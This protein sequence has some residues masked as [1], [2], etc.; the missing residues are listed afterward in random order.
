MS[1][2]P[3]D[4]RTVLWS[5]ASDDPAR[6]EGTQRVTLADDQLLK[7]LAGE[8]RARQS[9]ADQLEE[10]A[11]VALGVHRTA[12]RCVELLLR[13]GPL[14]AGELSARLGLS[15][16]GTTPLLD[17]L[18]EAGTIRRVRTAE[19]DRR[20]ITIE[21]TADGRAVAQ[22]VW[23]DLYEPLAQLAGEYER[24]DLE[25]VQEFLR[26]ANAILGSGDGTAD[27]PDEPRSTVPVGDP[28]RPESVPEERGTFRSRRPSRPANRLR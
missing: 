3:S 11:A 25:L 20:R 9:A 13:S 24:R 27:V 17:R 26:R 5:F 12:A 8:L 2:E 4:R 14:S 15:P 6:D 18:E 28:P 7:E 16:S 23:E 21:L 19:G 1:N 10:R 22:G